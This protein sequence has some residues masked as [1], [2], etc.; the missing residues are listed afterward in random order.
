LKCDAVYQTWTD[1]A[2]DNESMPL[3]CVTWYEAM[4][5][6]IWDG[7]FLATESEWNYAAA[8]GSEQRAYPWSPSSTPGATTIDCSH[9]NYRSNIPQGSYCVNGT[10]GSTNTGGS[11]APRG[12]GKWGQSDLAGNLLEWTLDWFAP[13]SAS[14]CNDC[15]NLTDGSYR[16][17]RG[18]SFYS[19]ASELRNGYR[20]TNAPSNPT[21]NIGVRCARTR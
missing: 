8:G 20:F 10:T 3:N 21:F 1:T 12:D 13:Y 15:A 11:E 17:V 19:S 4:A 5:F 14:Q 2:G 16:V 9:A 18:G 7:G 6:C